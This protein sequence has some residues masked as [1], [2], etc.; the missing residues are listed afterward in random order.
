EVA[1]GYTVSLSQPAVTDVVVKLTYSGTATDGSDYTAVTSV[2]VPAGQTSATFDITTID[3]ALA[4]G[5]ETITVSL[6]EITGGGFEAI[7]GNPAQATVTTSITD[8]AGPFGPGTPEP[9]DTC[10]VSISGPGSVVEG[11]VAS[12]YTV[13]LSQPAVTDVVVKLTY[14]GTAT[15]GSDYT[16]VT[17]VT[18]PAGQTSA[19]FDIATIDDALAEGTETITVSLG[20][21]TGGGFEAIAGNPAQ[22]T[23]TVTTSL[24]DDSGPFGPEDTCLVSISGPGSV[25]EGEVASGYTVSLTQPAVTDVVVKLTY[26]GTATDGSDYTAVTSVTV[27]AGQT[28]ATFDITTID[29]ALAEGTE[30]ITVSLGEITGGGFEAIAGNPAQATVTVTTS[31]VDDSGPF[32]P[33]DT[34]LVSISG[35]GSVVEGEVA[36]G[37]TVSLSQPAVTDVVVKLTYTGTA[38]DGSDYTAVTEVTIPAG[39]SSASFDI[40]TIDDAQ[41]ESCES[42]TVALGEITGGGFEQIAGSPLHA[43]VT[44]S[45]QDDTGPFGPGTPGPED[46]CLVSITGPDAVVEGEV[47][48]GYTVTLSQASTSDVVVQLSYSGTAEAGVDYTKVASITIPPGVTSYSFGIS[49]L[50]DAL[51]EGAE[52]F[53]VQLGTVSGGSFEAIALDPA[54][55]SVTT[56]I[57][58]DVGPMAPNNPPGTPDA[59]DTVLVSITGPDTVVEGETSG[60]YV[61][62]LSQPAVTDVVVR[63]VYTGTATDGADYVR[64]SSVTIPAGQ[65]STTFHLATIDDA[66]AEGTETITVALGQISGGG[67]EV[68]AGN[69]AQASVTTALVD[70]SGPLVPGGGQP[71]DAQDTVL[72]SLT[73][74]GSVLEGETASGYTVTLSQA[75]QTDVQVTLSYSGTASGGADYTQVLSV[76]VPAGQTSASFDLATLDDA[77]AEGTESIV[78]A[79][80]DITG[81]GFEAVLAN[82]LATSVTTCLVDDVGPGGATPGAEDTAQVSLT[83]PGQVLEGEVAT[84]Y[85]VTLSQPAVTDVV[86]KLNYAGTATDGADYTRVATVTIPAGQSSVQFD[87]ATLPDAAAEGAENF[88]VALGAI[89]G[90]GFEEI[91]GNPSAYA[92]T[93]TITDTAHA[94]TPQDDV[95]TVREDQPLSGN[96]LANDSDPDG[97]PLSVAGYTWGDVHHP[98]GSTATLPGIGTLVVEADGRYTFTPAKDYAGPVPEVSCV[99]SD[100]ALTT[101]SNLTLTI[102][103]VNDAPTLLGTRVALSE[104]GLPGGLP[105][106]GTGPHAT[107]AS[108]TLQFSDVDSPTLHFTLEAPTG[109]Y[110][111][112]GQALVWSG[113][114]SADQPLVGTAGGQVVLSATIDA[115]GHY[116]V[117]LHGPLDHPV[118]NA[119]DTLTLSLGVQV[120]DGQSTS[121]ATLDVTVR[122]DSPTPFCTARSADL[123][124]VQNNLLITLD[125]SGSMGTRDGVNGESRLQSAIKSITKL[126]DSYDN[127][128]EVAVRLV[129][130]S[131]TGAERG[132][133][134]MSAAEAKSTLASLCAG[135]NTN[136]DAALDAARGAFTDSGHLDGGHNVAYFFSDGRPNLPTGDVGID[137]GEA[138][139]WQNFLNQN[140]IQ[141]Y[142]VGL[143]KDVPV[144]AL[145]PVAWNGVTG[146]D[147]LSPLLVTSFSQ[148]DTVLAHTVAPAISG[149]VVDGGLH[150]VTGADGGHL[151]DIV[152]NGV[153]H[154]WD[155]ATS[156]SDTVTFK[157][158]TGGEFTFDMETGH[159]TY[160]APAGARTDYQEVLSF[161]VTDRDGDTRAGHMTL[162]INADGS[163]RYDGQCTPPAPTEPAPS[164][165]LSGGVLSWTLADHQTDTSACS[166]TTSTSTTTSSGSGDGGLHLSDVLGSSGSHDTLSSW[167]G[168]SCS[169]STSSGTGAG[170]GTGGT[171]TSTSADGLSSGSTV[172]TQLAQTLIQQPIDA[173]HGC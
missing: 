55:T 125:V 140:D 71:P 14:T 148:L 153:H 58:D 97:D 79:L 95:S 123:S 82:P 106:A 96:V 6:G 45:I 39:Q 72:V 4:E 67:F 129:T 65:S 15:D 34:C 141:S 28:S 31:L 76:T 131:T 150:S 164:T 138:Q 29:D 23:V 26:T 151:S 24:V 161:T 156:A 16:A 94:P 74:P 64:T 12:G 27:P 18:V 88:T 115:Q 48:S 10:L 69:P 142:A 7:A 36:S 90:G 126:I 104:A 87:I 122:D 47:A 135:G 100:G 44:T 112:G 73:G 103:G 54:H 110:A 51:A 35:P 169:T 50:D 80:G 132:D 92:V 166:T 30:T 37:Y 33:E 159:Y 40:A 81:G 93:T 157:T 59:S 118:R 46:T 66:L 128:G 83:G 117:E 111:S 32:G 155:P 49:T 158:A 11:E 139:V 2:T 84:G 124:L 91:R 25:V 154:P 134:W 77:L 114:G 99:V 102:E 38:T 143:G 113:D 149:D 171:S 9:E 89:S 98:A 165:C 109:L 101:V 136:Y 173:L 43:S 5:T 108:G 68:I 105:D 145:E 75:A 168:S 17:S 127:Q 162:S 107:Q 41:A 133:H 137:A 163:S 130:F 144:S 52:Q 42:Y 3:D 19:T 57:V 20:E 146:T 160:Q 61:V 152:V 13:S 63:L 1:S 78:V 62:S 119:E 86:I 85:T 147:D 120:S 22:A 116:T 167:S 21:I 60:G 121:S 53:S 8:D 172:D 170:T 70:D 56:S